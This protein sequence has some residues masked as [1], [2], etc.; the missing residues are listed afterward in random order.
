MASNSAMARSSKVWLGG[1]VTL[2]GTWSG[3]TGAG[4]SGRSTKRRLWKARGAEPMAGP[5]LTS[6]ASRR[7]A[8]DLVSNASRI[9]GFLARMSSNTALELLA[10]EGGDLGKANPLAPNA[11]RSAGYWADMSCSMTLAL[12]SYSGGVSGSSTPLVLSAS[13]IAGYSAAICFM[14]LALPSYFGGFSGSTTPLA[15]SASRIAGY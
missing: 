9:A 10:N 15:L 6:V 4:V 13:R 5:A 11:F 8:N 1:L 12:P 3:P 2:A 14:A 7:V